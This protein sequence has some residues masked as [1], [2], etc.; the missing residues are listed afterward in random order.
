MGAK[1]SKPTSI[2]S[3]IDASKS[4]GKTA[5]F[6]F[7]RESFFNLKLQKK[8]D[9][10]AIYNYYIFDPVQKKFIHLQSHVE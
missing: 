8:F 7:A 2:R 6:E 4:G 5:D 9:D 3:R 10:R 1:V